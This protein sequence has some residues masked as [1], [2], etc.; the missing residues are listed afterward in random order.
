VNNEING[1]DGIK[2]MIGEE[3]VSKIKHMLGVLLRG[4][5]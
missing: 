5:K 4:E 1:P 2:D 3:Y